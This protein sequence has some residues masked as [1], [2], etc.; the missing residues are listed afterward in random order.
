MYHHQTSLTHLVTYISANGMKVAESEDTTVGVPRPKEVL[1][2]GAASLEAV[3]ALA[4]TL[5]SQME[6]Y[7]VTDAADRK[8]KV[9]GGDWLRA[10]SNPARYDFLWYHALSVFLRPP[11]SEEAREQLI[12][13]I[14][15]MA[16][17]LEWLS[18]TL[19]KVYA[20]SAGAI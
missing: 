17:V 4:S 7:V 15:D 13:S 2:A 9:K 11:P 18:V 12:E 20:S 19:E 8:I 3:Q 16:V 14:P 6:G 5:N 1:L 10:H